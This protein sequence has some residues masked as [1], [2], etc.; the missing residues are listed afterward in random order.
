MKD[1]IAP[2]S[3]KGAP[4]IFSMHGHNTVSVPVLGLPQPYTLVRGAEAHICTK[5]HISRMNIRSIRSGGG[6]DSEGWTFPALAAMQ[7]GAIHGKGQSIHDSFS[8]P[9]RA[10]FECHLPAVSQLG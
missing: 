10:K 6:E 8:A 7:R 1:A 2:D 5:L 3:N 4:H 9:V